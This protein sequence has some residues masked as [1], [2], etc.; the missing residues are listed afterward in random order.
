MDR[1]SSELGKLNK[2]LPA[3]DESGPPP[4]DLSKLSFEE[5]MALGENAARKLASIA[6]QHAPLMALDRLEERLPDD[7][8]SKQEA[9]AFLTRLVEQSRGS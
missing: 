6:F 7:A 4:V 2:M 9:N 3:T 8:P 1:A 5:K